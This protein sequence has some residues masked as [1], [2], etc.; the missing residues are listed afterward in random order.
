MAATNIK[1]KWVSG[2]LK[3][4]NNSGTEVFAITST[5]VSLQNVSFG[6]SDI[7]YFGDSNDVGIQWDGT[8]FLISALAD[9]ELIEIGDAG[10][11]QKS[12]DIKW[13]GNSAAGADYLYF[14]AS[15]NLIYT[16]GI[17][18]QFKDNDILVFGT[19][20]GASGDIQLYWDATDMLMTGT[21]ASSEFKIGASGHVINA[22]LTGMLTVGVDDTGYDVKFYGAT[23]GKYML[24]DESADK[25][26]VVGT[27][28]LGSTC[29]AD[30]YT[31]GGVSGV[32]F[33][34]APASI[35]VVKGIVTAASST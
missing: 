4:Y 15:A 12:F 28:D 2:N 20:S 3:F 34:G 23:T 18:L 30:A 9:D 14:D 13:Y 35:T 29:E 22:T 7:L 5:G 6:V 11:T 31:V 10:A 21:A 19:G 1:S 26:I 8:N 25:L 27:A 33:T 32:D 16:T 24:W 17:D